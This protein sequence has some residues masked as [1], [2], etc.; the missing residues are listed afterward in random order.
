[1][2]APLARAR[3]R[4]QRYVGGI[5]DLA[6]LD[7][8][9]S[10][11]NHVDLERQARHPHAVTRV[12]DDGDGVEGDLVALF[13]GADAE[14][15]VIVE[16]QHRLRQ[17]VRRHGAE[18]DRRVAVMPDSTLPSALGRSISTGNDRVASSAVGAM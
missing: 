3:P 5:D 17:Q 8:F 9:L 12:A 10:D 1:M 6:G 4:R 16:R 14:H 18:A 15:A 11:G 2:T 7:E 13:D